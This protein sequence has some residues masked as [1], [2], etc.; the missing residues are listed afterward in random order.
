MAQFIFSLT[1]SSFDGT[2][3]KPKPELYLAAFSLPALS[4]ST[5]QTQQDVVCKHGNASVASLNCFFAFLFQ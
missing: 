5:T 3:H 2:T 1:H 4:N